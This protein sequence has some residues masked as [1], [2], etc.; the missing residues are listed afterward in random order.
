M[1]GVGALRRR[2]GF[3][4][5]MLACVSLSGC[6]TM[7][8]G[9]DRLYSVQDEVAQARAL[10]DNAAPEGIPGLVRRY[11]SVGSSNP[12]ADDA[13]RMYLRNEIIARRMYII[14]VEYTEYETALLNERQKFGFGTSLAAQSLT[15]ASALTTPLRSAQIVA[16]VAS[17]VG[18]SRGF[19][20]SEVVIA[21]TIQIAQGHMRAKRDNVAK[22]ILPLRTTSAV[23]Y[24]LSAALRDLEDYY[25]AGTLTSGLVEAVGQAGEVAH[26]AAVEK[27]GMIMAVYAADDTSLKLTKFLKTPKNF[28][29]AQKCLP[30]SAGI[31]D[32]RAILDDS[33]LVAVRQQVI[34]C[35]KL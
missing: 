31:G 23:L 19:Y 7:D 3:S 17:G 22:R 28:V 4:V 18:A 11:Y 20:D 5:L 10:L 27:S 16:G 1:R 21:K 13:Q 25:N 15:I 2:V 24:P 35:L 26:T 14:D 34:A 12:A 29:A 6:K 8:G 33:T 30:V 9:P 32:V